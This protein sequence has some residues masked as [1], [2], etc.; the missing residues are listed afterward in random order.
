MSSVAQ[1]SPA[2]L[3]SRVLVEGSKVCDDGGGFETEL[4]DVRV[5]SGWMPAA[6]LAKR[7]TVGGVTAEL[8]D[9]DDPSGVTRQRWGGQPPQV[10]YQRRTNITAPIGTRFRRH[11]WRPVVDRNKTVGDYLRAGDV[12][13]TRRKFVAEFELCGDGWLASARELSARRTRASQETPRPEKPPSKE[14]TRQHA[15][16]V[17]AMLSG[18]GVPG[19]ST[20]ARP[21]SSGGSGKEAALAERAEAEPQNPSPLAGAPARRRTPVRQSE[22]T[23]AEERT[24]KRGVG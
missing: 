6:Q 2:R 16:N 18:A 22:T 8:L 17:L 9:E 24:G 20:G 13:P 23:R 3:A 1:A 14:E 12:F 5:N 7:G 11:I 4:W 21:G 10:Y 19:R 15:A